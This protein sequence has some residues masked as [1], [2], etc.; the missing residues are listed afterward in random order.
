MCINAYSER[1]LLKTYFNVSDDG[2]ISIFCSY[3]VLALVCFAE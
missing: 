3:N 2:K 1:D